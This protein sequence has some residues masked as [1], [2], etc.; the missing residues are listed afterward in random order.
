MDVYQRNFSNTKKS[1]F[2][3]FYGKALQSYL[4]F[5]HHII[6]VPD[7]IQQESYN[8]VRSLKIGVSCVRATR[9]IKGLAE[10]SDKRAILLQ[11]NYSVDKNDQTWCA[12][13]WA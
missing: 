8:L 6:S 12:V 3:R 2:I 5:D 1:K 7:E 4:S 11:S 9:S 13:H 10:G